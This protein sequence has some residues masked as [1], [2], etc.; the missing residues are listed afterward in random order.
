MVALSIVVPVHNERANLPGLR[1]EIEAVCDSLD[2]RWQPWEL[3]WVEDGSTDGTAEWVDDHATTAE[4]VT[5]IHLRRSFGQS[6]ALAAG[7]DRAKGGVIVPM[8]GDQ[9][10]DPADIPDLL[11]R[12]DA[13]ADCV[14][15]WRHDRDDPWHKTI[16]SAIQTHLAKY[17]GPDIHD[18]GCTLTAYRA[19]ALE[20][21]DLRGESHRYLPAQLYDKGY[22]VEEVKVNHRPREHGQSRYGLGR[23]LR[24]FVDLVFHWFWVRYSTRPMHLLGGSGFVMLGLGGLL[25]GAS[26]VQRFAFG[27]ALL[28]HLPRLVLVALLIITG[29]LLVVFGFLAEMITKLHYSTDTEYRIERVVE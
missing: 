10:N 18:F 4:N 19:D 29:L 22:T 2:V 23:L 27:E 1:E 24:G 28:S 26:L 17:T 12:I 14:S 9:Q 13:G 11:A 6:A 21:I 20:A 3:I 5:T 15:G 16:P 25:G 8:D 7:F